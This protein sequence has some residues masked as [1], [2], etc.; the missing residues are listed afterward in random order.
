MRY[1]FRTLWPPKRPLSLD[2]S[3]V[4]RAQLI[5]PCLHKEGNSHEVLFPLSAKQSESTNPGITSPSTF[6][7]QVFSTSERF[8][9][10]TVL[11]PCFM[12]LALVGFTL[13]SVPPKNSTV[14]SSRL[15][16]SWLPIDHPSFIRKQAPRVE[17]DQPDVTAL[18]DSATQQTSGQKVLI[19]FQV[20]SHPGPVLPST[21]GRYSLGFWRLLRELTI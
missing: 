11:R 21:G 7:L 16:P 10:R 5:M 14:L 20:R 17:L 4:S 19:R 1:S 9:P 12:P 13:Q 2:L 3:L 18:T 15:V 8:T 6:R